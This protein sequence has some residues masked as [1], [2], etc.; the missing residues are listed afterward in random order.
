MDGMQFKRLNVGVWL[1]E[2]W[3]YGKNTNPGKKT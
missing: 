1:D 2:V 3:D